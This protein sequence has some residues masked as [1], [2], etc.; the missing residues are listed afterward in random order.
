MNKALDRAQ[1]AF[2]DGEINLIYWY[3][4]SANAVVDRFSEF[5][6]CVIAFGVGL[7]LIRRLFSL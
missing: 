4:S 5:I 1:R 2:F 7:R 3:G 6:Y